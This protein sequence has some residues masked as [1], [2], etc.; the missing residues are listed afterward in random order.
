[1]TVMQK[2]SKQK[3][4]KTLPRRISFFFPLLVQYEIDLFSVAIWYVV[5]IL[6]VLGRD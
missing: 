2:I 5:S 4:E 1:M 6:N 3:N